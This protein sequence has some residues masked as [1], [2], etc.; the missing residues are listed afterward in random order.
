MAVVLCRQRGQ[1]LLNNGPLDDES[2]QSAVGMPGSYGQIQTPN[3]SS[4]A[5]SP[6]SGFPRCHSDSS[7]DE[8][9]VDMLNDADIDKDVFRF[10]IRLI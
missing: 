8:T 6:G 9:D 7:L 10:Y 1:Q 3:A 2:I 4:S 5:T